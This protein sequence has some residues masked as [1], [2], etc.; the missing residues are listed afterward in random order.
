MDVRRLEIPADLAAQLHLAEGHHHARTNKVTEV[1][2]P[3]VKAKVDLSL[4]PDINSFPFST[5]IRSHFQEMGLP[6]L[7]QPLKQPLTRL[8]GE[9]RQTALQLNKVILRFIGDKGL[10]AWQEEVLGNYIAS[11]GLASPSLR[12]ELLSQVVSQV[13]KNMDLEQCQRGWVLMATLLGTFAPSPALEKP[14][15]KFVSDHGLESY[16]GICQRKLLMSMQQMEKDPE[17]SRSFPPTQLEWT[18]NQ[19]KG[20]M[21]LDVYT[22]KGKRG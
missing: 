11:R 9:Q 17:V 2:P 4:P 8:D 3:E 6:D 15:L 18:T 22:Y 14:L 16:N 10:E 13:W 19:R 1:S 5:F 21:V 12:D 7:G 20:K